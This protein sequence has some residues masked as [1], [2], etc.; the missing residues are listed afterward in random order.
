MIFDSLKQKQKVI[1]L[2]GEVPVTTTIKGILSGPSNDL[3]ALMERLVNAQVMDVD[4]QTIA[5]MEWEERNRGTAAV[6]DD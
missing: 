1:D 5:L 2:I 4:D 6:S 3:K